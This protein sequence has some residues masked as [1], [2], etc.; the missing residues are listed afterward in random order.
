MSF[1]NPEIPLKRKEESHHPWENRIKDIH[2]NTFKYSHNSTRN[3]EY[4]VKKKEAP[5]HRVQ[6]T[7]IGNRITKEFIYC[8]H[9]VKGLYKYKQ[10]EFEPPI[11][12]GVT[13]VEW[14]K[15]WNDLKIHYGGTAYCL[16][17]QVAVLIDKQFIGGENELKE[18]VETKY[19]YNVNVNYHK[20]GI[21]QFTDFV[22]SSGRPC[23]Y[24]HIAIDEEPI[25]VLIFMLYADICPFTC[26]NFLRMCEN[27]KGG[28]AGT[29]IHRI[30]KDCWIQGGGFFL[31]SKTELGC[32]NFIVP[33][34]RRGVLCM[35]NDGRHINCSTQFFVLLQPAP[36]M[37]HK[38]VAF[39]QLIEGEGTLEKIENVPTWYEAP[40]AEIRI[41][42][43]GVF[44]MECHW[45][46]VNK[47]TN[48]YLS[49]H[50]EDL[51]VIAEIFY[52]ALIE[53]VFREAQLRELERLEDGF[54]TEGTEIFSSPTHTKKS[55][56][57]PVNN[58]FDVDVYTYEF[59]EYSY[60]KLSRI[61][62]LVVRPEQAYY[63][64]FT[65][66]PYPGEIDST[67]DLQ[68]L[69][70]GDYC[71]G[72]DIEEDRLKRAG[73]K[74][75]MDVPDVLLDHL[76]E[77]YDDQHRVSE[78]SLDSDDENIIKEY[79]KENADRASFAG[80]IIKKMAGLANKYQLFDDTEGKKIDL[81]SDEELRLLRLAKK[82]AKSA[83][84][85]KVSISQPMSKNESRSKIKRRPT[86]FVRPEDIAQMRKFMRPSSMELDSE[87]DDE[88]Y[89]KV[90]IL[91]EAPSYEPPVVRRPLAPRTSEA[92]VRQ[93]V[94]IRLYDHVTAD[95]EDIIPTLKD[96]KPATETHHK[97]FSLLKNSPQLFHI[98]SDDD[99][100]Y[101]RRH[102]VPVD[103][104]VFNIQHGRL[105]TSKISSDYVRTMDQLEHNHENSIRSL[106]FAKIR[107][108]L[109][110][111]AYQKK[112]KKYQD[113]LTAKQKES[114]GGIRLP[115]D[116]PLYQSEIDIH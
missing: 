55:T 32:E 84:E 87:E 22:Q 105:V 73:A 42:K 71:L 35:A 81:I 1:F 46:P 18:I 91:S 39:G 30:V 53:N 106:E 104:S 25:G 66:V 23:A 51:L 20:E 59:E 89:R 110:V 8:L 68:K 112:N 2:T 99:D 85:K 115:G 44:N 14:P 26:E 10:K 57:P 21:K 60:D 98:K 70:R 62:S 109:S 63:I 41:Y 78:Y 82:E 38:Y 100:K 102:S 47:D 114:G 92:P 75:H 65:D 17:S 12:R 43:A 40:T 69:L 34:D 50:V 80:P 29:P 52:E 58:E 64:P 5:V 77:C 24:L 6:F 4:P 3:V 61:E 116:T 93:S 72:S 83:R 94:L 48:A 27:P 86:G 79:I 97:K 15:V 90:Q 13:S 88:V 37:L 101:M 45:I 9:L 31:K 108:A 113:E 19:K 54:M 67:F 33:H 28:Y 76:F 11:I 36:W 111:E 96:Y 49:G 7:I 16:K 95:S 107:P 56:S 103:E 74:I